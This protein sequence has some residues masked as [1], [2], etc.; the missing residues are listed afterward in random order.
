MPGRFFTRHANTPR[1]GR[2]WKHVYDSAK[3][4][5]A[6]VSSAIRQASGVVRRTAKADKRQRRTGRRH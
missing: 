1:R 6:S 3:S 2:Q 4:R 5:G